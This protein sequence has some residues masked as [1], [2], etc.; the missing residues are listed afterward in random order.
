MCVISYLEIDIEIY[1]KDFEGNKQW[2][3]VKWL[4][5]YIKLFRKF[6][7]EEQVLPSVGD[8]R[9]F[10]VNRGDGEWVWRVLSA[11]RDI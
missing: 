9:V 2:K 11:E 4:E 8:I 5:S 6:G 10:R 3:H 1:W 7:W